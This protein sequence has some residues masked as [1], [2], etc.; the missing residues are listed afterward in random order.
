[1][2]YT[3]KSKIEKVNSNRVWVMS[4]LSQTGCARKASLR[5]C[6]IRDLR[7]G[8]GG[9]V[10]TAERRLLLAEVMTYINPETETILSV[11]TEEKLGVKGGKTI[12]EW[13]GGRTWRA[14]W[15]SVRRPQ[16]FILGVMG[17]FQTPEWHN[18]PSF[19]S[20]LTKHLLRAWRCARL[21]FFI[22]HWFA[23]FYAPYKY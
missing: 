2:C 12:D 15:T 16:D 7:E 18:P 20:A 19:L 4:W 22:T 17:R 9:A 10:C 8:T 3:E 1:M 13:L 6:L 5:R 11:L 23:L 21:T 14:S